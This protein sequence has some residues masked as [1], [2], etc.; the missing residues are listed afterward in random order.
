M[1]EI[2]FMACGLEGCSQVHNEEIICMFLSTEEITT[3]TRWLLEN[4]SPPVKYLTYKHILKTDPES[5]PMEDLWRRVENSSAAKELFSGQ[6]EDG[7][8]FSGGPWG[9]RGYRHQTG[10]GYT[11]SHD[12]SLSPQPGSCH[13]SEKWGLPLTMRG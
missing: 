4:A 2:Y 8:W 1:T 9:P 5:K 12:L 7:S 6:N 10:R 3:S 13:F 11:L